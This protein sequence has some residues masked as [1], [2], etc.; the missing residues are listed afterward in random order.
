M[1]EYIVLT[2]TLAMLLYFLYKLKAQK[3][4]RGLNGFSAGVLLIICI[5]KA[6]PIFARLM[7]DYLFR[8]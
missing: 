2:A 8:N 6:A 3:Q 7:K 1:N 5:F 4:N